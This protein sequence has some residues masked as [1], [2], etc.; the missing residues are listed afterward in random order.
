MR[1]LAGLFLVAHGIV[2]L[3]I[4]LPIKTEDA[5]FDVHHSPIFGDVRVPASMLAVVAGGAFM[6]AGAS[7]L[8]HQ[9]WAPVVV[10]G[11][12]GLSGALLLLTF[13]PWWLAGL[14]IDLAVGI[15]A[16]RAWGKG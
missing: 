2:H 7:V 3:L 16:I 8:A 10:V 5:P 14:A 1:L 12:A 15:L 4:W 13:T 6:V 9:A 11:A